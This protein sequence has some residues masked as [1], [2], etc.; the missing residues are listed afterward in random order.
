MRIK[1]AIYTAVLFFFVSGLCS[2]SSTTLT[3]FPRKANR[4]KDTIWVEKE[5]SMGDPYSSLIKYV[6][7][8]VENYLKKSGW[9]VVEYGRTVES[10]KANEVYEYCTKRH[11]WS[12]PEYDECYRENAWWERA[13]EKADH[14]LVIDSVLK[15]TE[16]YVKIN[17]RSDLGRFTPDTKFGQIE[18]ACP[19][20]GS[21]P[22]NIGDMTCT[23]YKCKDYIVTAVIK[24][25]RQVGI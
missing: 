2:C 18:I 21:C 6:N 3:D 1:A 25:L 9:N 12:S 13:E 16:Q 7:R 19:I 5:S 20:G 23:Q 17:I 24:K 8:E 14:V 15:S 11:D 22:E 4:N 10:G